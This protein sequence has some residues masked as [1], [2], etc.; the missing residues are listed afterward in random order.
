MK[1]VFGDFSSVFKFNL[2]E[3]IFQIFKDFLGALIFHFFLEIRINFI[4]ELANVGEGSFDHQ[5]II[6]A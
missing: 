3:R 2:K 6:E 5:I 1:D 4:K